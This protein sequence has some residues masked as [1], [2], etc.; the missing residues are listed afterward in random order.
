MHHVVADYFGNEI[1]LG[2]SRKTQGYSC[3]TN[4]ILVYDYVAYGQIIIVTIEWEEL[5]S[6]KAYN[7]SRV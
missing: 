5:I 3:V 4:C 6:V 7:E 1:I 2:S